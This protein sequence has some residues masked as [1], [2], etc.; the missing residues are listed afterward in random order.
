VT[1]MYCPVCARRLERD[2]FH[3][4]YGTAP[5]PG[6]AL[7]VIAESTTMT[8]SLNH[9]KTR[10]RSGLID[11]RRTSATFDGITESALDAVKS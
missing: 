1:A 10:R 6:L 11:V 3:P 2:E 4:A 5:A 7:T 9:A 8:M